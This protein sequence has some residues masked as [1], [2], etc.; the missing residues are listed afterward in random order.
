MTE[1]DDHDSTLNVDLFPGERIAASEPETLE[2]SSDAE[3]SARYLSN[4]VRIV[5][6]QARYPLNQIH[7][8]L[9]RKTESES[10]EFEFTYN[11]D[12]EY[13]RRHRWDATRKSRLIESFLMNVPVPPIFLYE[14]ELA[15]YE[16]MDGRQ[17]L[18][19]LMDFYSDSLVLEGLQHWPEL[20]GRTYKSL[21]TAI[22]NGIDRRYL[23]SIILLNETAAAGEQAALLKKLVF[24]R[25]NSG[26][27]ELSGQ[28]TRNAIFDGPVNSLCI[29]LSELPEF[30]E[31][32]GVPFDVP[33]SSG[34]TQ[35]GGDVDDENESP[36]LRKGTPIGRKWYE[37]MDDVE[38]VLRFFAYRHLRNFSQGLN[39]I[40]EFLDQFL[41]KANT[42][43]N[44]TIEAYRS[45]FTEN[46]KFWYAVGG[47]NAF[48]PRG[49]SRSRHFSK[50]AYDALMYSSSA[51]TPEQ[52]EILMK[53]P[54]VLNRSIN[55][56]YEKN[57]DA[58]G[59]RK[60]NASDAHRRN[61]YAFE[62]L[63]SALTQI[64]A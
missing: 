5:T 46:I 51:L 64:Q 22:R 23:S 26:G 28:E 50:I 6:E 45:L 24:E 25:L 62:A 42:F 10:G 29:E 3:L 18:S 60:T 52:R 8:M 27:V 43:D 21:P 44:A 32:V 30:K 17:R 4:G 11:R 16:V 1:P 37:S 57:S 2:Q 33:E 36:D 59:G 15:R 40:R 41:L 9:T 38:L 20:N 39:R 35:D 63:Q 12:P 47:P 48:Q 13:Q 55:E 7:S 56:M 34:T 19:A 49:I 31:M 58:F 54:D 53:H 14:N 61:L